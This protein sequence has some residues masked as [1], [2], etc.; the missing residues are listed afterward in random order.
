MLIKS[1]LSEVHQGQFPLVKPGCLLAHGLIFDDDPAFCRGFSMFFGLGEVL[2]VA[3]HEAFPAG[4]IAALSAALDH[5][6]GGQSLD[7]SKGG[8]NVVKP[9]MWFPS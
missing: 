8:G 6:G 1:P 2:M 5:S 3:C 9:G 7:L 4:C